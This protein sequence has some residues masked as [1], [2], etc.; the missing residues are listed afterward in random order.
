M[1]SINEI[2]WMS[3]RKGKR[4]SWLK[5]CP[6]KLFL[7]K[8]IQRMGWGQVRRSHME[9][10]HNINMHKEFS[11]R[12]SSSS[13]QLMG[14]TGSLGNSSEWLQHFSISFFPYFKWRVR[15]MCFLC[16]A[17]SRWIQFVKFAAQT[18]FLMETKLHKGTDME[19]RRDERIYEEEYIQSHSIIFCST[20]GFQKPSVLH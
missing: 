18:A 3:L 17:A 5:E 9:N 1:E 19:G 11:P 13:L 14:Q 10:M 20:G 6:H 15:Q 4:K 16:M 12:T 7:F 2:L 8:W